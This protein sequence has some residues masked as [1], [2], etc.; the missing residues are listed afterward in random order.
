MIHIEEVDNDRYNIKFEG[1]TEEL[2]GEVC[3]ILAS[4]CTEMEAEPEDMLYDIAMNFIPAYPEAR[5]RMMSLSEWL[6][7]SAEELIES[8][9]IPS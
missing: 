1:D 4:I 7:E 8:E 9:G 2:L 5:E 3:T 6:R